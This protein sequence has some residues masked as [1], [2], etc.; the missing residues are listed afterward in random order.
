MVGALI[1]WII[2]QPLQ[3][4]LRIWLGI[5]SRLFQYTVFH[6]DEDTRGFCGLTFTNDALWQEKMLK[7]LQEMAEKQVRLEGQ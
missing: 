3:I 1:I 6:S 2:T 5:G 4:M 7:D